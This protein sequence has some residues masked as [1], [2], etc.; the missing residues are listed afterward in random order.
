MMDRVRAAFICMRWLRHLRRKNVKF[1][2]PPV[3]EGTWP[4][5]VAE[6]PLIV[7]ASC[8]FRSFRFR[9]VLT[10]FAG[11]RLEIGDH[12]YINDGVNI[13]SAQSI[14]IG[15]HSRIA[16][17][18]VIYDTDFH[19]IAPDSPVRRG[20][21]VIGRNVWIGAR[22]MILPGVTIGDHSVIAA[23]AVVTKDIPGR[24]IAAGSP[25]TVI[26]TLEC[27]DDWVRR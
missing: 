23:G 11:G 13:C 4:D 18:V 25:A 6:G 7:G 20:N 22:A 8:T 24:S 16:D 10:V 12:S 14:V 2:S 9:T 21:V 1:R 17:M 15:P 3:V 26:R 27:P 5:L 19:Q